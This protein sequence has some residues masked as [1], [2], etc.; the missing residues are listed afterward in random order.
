MELYAGLR[1]ILGFKELQ[2]EAENLKEAF[3][4]LIEKGGEALRNPLFD[5]EGR[6]KGEYIVL[7]DGKI[8]PNEAEYSKVKLGR[9]GLVSILMMIAGG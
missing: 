8:V 5:M 9:E 3:D 4:R 7:V 1:D 2:V 6:L